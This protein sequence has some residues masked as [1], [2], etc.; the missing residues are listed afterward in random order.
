LKYYK[1]RYK[2][3]SSGKINRYQ[4]D[5]ILEKSS[6]STLIKSCHNYPGAEI[7]I[8]HKLLI[9]KCS[10]KYSKYK[11]YQ[12]RNRNPL[13]ETFRSLKNTEIKELFA[14]RTKKNVKII[15]GQSDWNSIKEGILNAAN[16]T[17]KREALIPRKPWITQ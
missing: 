2:W 8:D 3:I 5:Y 1:R 6:Y 17:L 11:N 4:I 10:L 9:A 14:N 7:D 15:N 16:T 12:V 13:S